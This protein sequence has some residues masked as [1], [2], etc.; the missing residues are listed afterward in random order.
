MAHPFHLLLFCL[1]HP[2]S[3]T[4]LSPFYRLGRIVAMNCDDLTHEQAGKLREVIGPH[5]EYLFRLRE[6]MTK[7]GFLT[8][9][10][11][12]QLVDKAYG[13]MHSLFIELHYMSCQ[14]G[15]CRPSKDVK[16][17][18]AGQVTKSE[19]PNE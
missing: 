1:F 17:D 5:M 2:F 10:K 3:A 13:A 8:D 19:T 14:S 16:A 9:D 7:M 12:Y 15:V 18:D 11:L 4:N 6:R